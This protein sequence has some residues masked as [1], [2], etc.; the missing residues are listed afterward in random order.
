MGRGPATEYDRMQRQEALE[1]AVTLR[2]KR[3]AEERVEEL[4]FLMSTPLGRRHVA[5]QLRESKLVERSSHQNAMVMADIGGK[6]ELGCDLYEAIQIHCPNEWLLLEKERID[7]ER[8]WR[9][10]TEQEEFAD[11]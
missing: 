1:A 7:A 5:R 3:R 11:G 2:N 8:M 4:R 10:E 6:R 9:R